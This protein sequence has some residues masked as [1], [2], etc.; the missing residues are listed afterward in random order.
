MK[1]SLIPSKQLS[2]AVSPAH[3]WQTSA[4]TAAALISL[5]SDRRS[6][7]EKLIWTIGCSLTA[8]PT[9]R[10]SL[11][12]TNRASASRTVALNKKRPRFKSGTRS[13]HFLNIPLEV[14]KSPACKTLPPSALKVLI[15]IAAQY[16]GYRNGD[17]SIARPIM[18]EF[19]MRSRRQ[20]Y[21]ARDVLEERGLII[22]TRQG[23]LHFGCNL[24]AVTWFGI[25]PCDG[26]HDVSPNPVPLNAWKSWQPKK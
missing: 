1:N 4:Y 13:K 18:E 2:T 6:L 14:L 26:K 19:G 24:Y 3:I 22:R 21:A 20:I 16:K 23:G 10:A 11:K 7:T 5:R 15:C 12:T 17:M 9:G 25:D 8:L